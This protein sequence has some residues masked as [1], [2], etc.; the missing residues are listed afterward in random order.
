MVITH[1]LNQLDIEF[2]VPKDPASNWKE[3]LLQTARYED[4]SIDYL[5]EGQGVSEFAGRIQGMIS[6]RARVELRLIPLPGKRIMAIDR[7]VA[8]GVDLTESL[9]SKMA[10]EKASVNAIESLLVRAANQLQKTQV[11][12]E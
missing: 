5:V 9:S 7:G 3:K 8:A 6:C 4:Q 11:R 10:L 1:F 2:V 12:E